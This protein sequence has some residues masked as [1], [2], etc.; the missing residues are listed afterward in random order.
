MPIPAVPPWPDQLDLVNLVDNI[1]AW[2]FN[3]LPNATSTVAENSHI[4]TTRRCI[5]FGFT[6]SSTLAAAQWIQLYDSQ[7]LPGSGA[8]PVASFE[9]ALT[10]TVT[11]NYWPG[12][13]FR[14]GLVIVNSTAQNSYTAGAANC[15]FDVQYL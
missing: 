9:V 10:N 14:N 7:A 4:C 3:I 5:L 11:I 13:F 6:A 2:A 1:T 8:I 15:L 12:R